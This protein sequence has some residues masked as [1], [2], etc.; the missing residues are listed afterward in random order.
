VIAAGLL[1]VLAGCAP[2]APAVP[3]VE[4][5]KGTSSLESNPV[6]VDARKADVAV[7]I[8]WNLHDFS[9]KD[10]RETLTAGRII[11]QYT[12]YTST[13]DDPGPRVFLGPEVWQPLSVTPT[14][15][16]ADLLICDV[17]SGWYLAKGH[18]AKLDLKSAFRE[19]IHLVRSG[20]RYLVDSRDL[21]RDRCD[22]T[23]APIGRF[24]P[25]PELPGD[26]S[27]SDV[28]EPPELHD[29]G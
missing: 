26:V 2:S 10:L 14:A 25:V 15:K 8:A 18:P 16:G 29:V 20:D 6:V 3:K 24:K 21:T 9:R 17:W 27:K 7:A 4:W 1:L 22:A 23:G 11:D 28:V 13:L 19:T 12:G 5:T